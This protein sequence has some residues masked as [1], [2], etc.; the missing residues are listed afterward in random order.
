MNNPCA[1]FA[2]DLA[3]GGPVRRWRARRHAARCP[4][5]ASV[6]DGLRR[7][8]RALAE[9]PPLTAAER[10]LWTAVADGE[11]RAEPARESRFFRP[12]LAGALAVAV[13]GVFGGWWA[14]R[15]VE[16]RSGPPAVTRVDP[17][18]SVAGPLPDVEALRP[19]LV[20]L[21]RD[22]DDLRRRADLLDARRDVNAL[23][24][25]LAPPGLSG[26]L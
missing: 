1:Q 21:A 10:R 17:L 2:A 7:V 23:A 20:A 16:R 3:A 8:V 25:R 14:S 11:G 12:A 6:R 4:R 26:G 18:R 13:V 19:G 24:A 15:P 5:C 9:A 22:L